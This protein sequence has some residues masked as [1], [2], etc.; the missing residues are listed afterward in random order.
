[1]FKL[2]QAHVSGQEED[3]RQPLEGRNLLDFARCLNDRLYGRPKSL[4]F[5]CVGIVQQVV[6]PSG[7]TRLPAQDLERRV[8][9]RLFSFLKSDAELF[10]AL[11]GPQDSP[12]NIQS[13]IAAA[14]KLAAKCV[15]VRIQDLRDVLISFLNNVIVCDDR[16]EL[17]IGRREL[18]E[19]LNPDNVP[20]PSEEPSKGQG[21][22]D[23]M[24]SLTIEAKLRRYGGN[25]HLVV[26][27]KGM[28]PTRHP[29]LALIKAIARGRAWYEMVME[30]KV[31]DMKSLARQTGLT[32]HYVR[33]VFACAFLAPDIVEAILEGRQPL[34][35]KF[36]DLYKHVPLS[37]VEQRERFG[38]A[39]LTSR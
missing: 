35:L 24:I 12:S 5:V 27:P 25:I 19:V 15:S 36:E 23:D 33:N 20:I 2:R 11:C 10:D 13:L 32:P 26:P 39:P 7:P 17:L 4:P 14:K 37:W 1:M 29:R 34:S 18:R 8:T 3:I 22:L 38:F 16:I 30:G 21:D 9:E 28:A 6:N 31:S